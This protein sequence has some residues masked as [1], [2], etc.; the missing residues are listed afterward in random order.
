M[1]LLAALMCNARVVH[2]SLCLLRLPFSPFLKGTSQRKTTVL[3]LPTWG[4]G[5][6]AEDRKRTRAETAAFRP[7]P[8]SVRG[9]RGVARCHRRVADDGNGAAGAGQPAIPRL[10]DGISDVRHHCSRRVVWL[11]MCGGCLI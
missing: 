3:R 7:G 11:F 6:L 4:A 2:L 10:G 1:F 8:A 9:L 5:R